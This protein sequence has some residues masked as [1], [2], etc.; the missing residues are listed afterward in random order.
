MFN[1][2]L[3]GWVDEGK[4][5][6]VGAAAMLAG[7]VR[8]TLSLAVIL[9]ECVG[10]ITFAFPLIII[11]MVAKWTGDFFNEVIFLYYFQSC[12]GMFTRITL[13]AKKEL[14]C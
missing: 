3:Q 8:M 10:N 12:V 6:L 7:V 13:N 14:F 9:M 11:L 5:A 1:L 2:I 4:Y